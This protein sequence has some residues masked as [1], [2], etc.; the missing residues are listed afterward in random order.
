MS[1]AIKLAYG[2]LCN[3]RGGR[4]ARACEAVSRAAAAREEGQRRTAFYNEQAENC[5]LRTYKMTLED[6]MSSVN[7]RALTR[8][9]HSSLRRL[10]SLVIRTS[11]TRSG[12]WS[13]TPPTM[14]RRNALGLRSLTRAFDCE[15]PQRRQLGRSGQIWT[16][17]FVYCEEK[18]QKFMK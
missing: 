17:L 12:S 11:M 1:G 4:N 2:G 6:C 14:L 15:R 10:C 5:A 16:M 9:E 13:A 3:V 18:K 8:R 7:V